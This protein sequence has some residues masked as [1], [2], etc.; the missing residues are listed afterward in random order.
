MLNT[1]L[2]EQLN[3][4]PTFINFGNVIHTLTS[5]NQSWVA[6]EDCAFIAN[7]DGGTNT[8]ANVSVNG[9]IVVSTPYIQSSN[10][11]CQW[12]A[13]PPIYVKKGDTVAT[14]DASDTGTYNVKFYSLY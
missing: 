2:V 5:Y 9:V 4:R 12:V 6:T 3:I 10:K 8:N 7:F 14:R 1:N 11:T 13:T